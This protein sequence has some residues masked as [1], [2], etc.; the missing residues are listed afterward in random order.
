MTLGGKSVS[1][2]SLRDAFEVDMSF[3]E[4]LAEM[5]EKL[6]QAVKLYDKLLLSYSF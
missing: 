6:S 4:L 3:S 2:S 1:A 5:H